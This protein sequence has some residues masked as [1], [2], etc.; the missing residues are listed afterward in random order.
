MTTDNHDQNHDDA[1]QIG[2]LACYIATLA[3]LGEH[4]GE[5]REAGA[6]LGVCRILAEQVRDLAGEIELR[7]LRAQREAAQ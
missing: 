6:A 4:H 1:T 5:M 7:E 2:A 3:D